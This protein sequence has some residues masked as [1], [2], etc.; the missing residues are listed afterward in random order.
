VPLETRLTSNFDITESRVLTLGQKYY[1]YIII[2]AGMVAMVMAHG[3]SAGMVLGAVSVLTICALSLRWPEIGLLSVFPLLYAMDPT[4]AGIGGREV[5]FAAL[6]VATFV[7]S[8]IQER[9]RLLEVL[10]GLFGKVVLVVTLF[11]C[12]NLWVALTYGVVFQDWLRGVIP[13][14]FIAYQVPVFL[15]V[16]AHPSLQTALFMSIGMTAALFSAHVVQVFIVQRLWVPRWYLFENNMWVPITEEMLSEKHYEGAK[17]FLKRVTMS[18][19]QSTDVLLP[20]SVLWG[21]AGYVLHSQRV[22]RLAALSGASLGTIAVIMTY[23]RSMWIT[24]GVASLGIGAMGWRKKNLPRFVIAC[25]VVGS[26]AFATIKACHLESLYLN[27]VFQTY[28]PF[29]AERNVNNEP[30]VLDENIMSRVEEYKVAWAMFTES[31][32]VGQGLGVRHHMK[33]PAGHGQ[34][35]EQEVGYIHNWVLY[36]LMVGGIVG[37][38]LYSWLIVGPGVLLMRK[39][40][41]PVEL[42]AALVTTLAAMTVYA[43]SF[44]VFRLLS[45]NLLIAVCWGVALAQRNPNLETE[46]R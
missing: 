35:V 24:V 9:L 18:L 19:Q 16:R 15:M 17:Q 7:G 45:F 5:L 31:P 3:G 30:R 4:P 2:L 26:V 33:F 11:L 46:T 20:L 34:F 8:V 25:F 28:S 10:R 38:A 44:A 14:V 41:L 43:L 32:W 1:G 42:R 21:I 37:F 36:M 40:S 12:I 13:F 39:R 6:L 23:T 27:R 22:W 29:S